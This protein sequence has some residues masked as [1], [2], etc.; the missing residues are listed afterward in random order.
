MTATLP[1]AQTTA[2]ER[3]SYI[4][5]LDALTAAEARGIRDRFEMIEA[6]AGR[7]VFRTHLRIKGHLVFPWMVEVASHPAILDRVEA[8]V[9]PDILLFASTM[10]IKNGGDGTFVSWHQDTPYFQLDPPG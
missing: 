9:G 1:P 6:K 3:N 10:W 4:C 7:D 5:P 8:L 2:F